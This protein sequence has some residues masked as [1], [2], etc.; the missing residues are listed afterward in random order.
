MTRAIKSANATGLDQS[1]WALLVSARDQYQTTPVIRHRSPFAFG[2]LRA[3]ISEER[4]GSVWVNGA[5]KDG[6]G[7]ALSILK[8]PNR[9]LDFARHGLSVDRLTCR[10]KRPHQPLR[11]RPLISGTTRAGALSSDMEFFFA[12]SILPGL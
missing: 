7:S 9:R 3:P 11:D 12:A 2:H 8:N 6:N 5:A 10:S 1:A 4:S